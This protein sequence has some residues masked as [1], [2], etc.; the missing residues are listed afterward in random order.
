MAI[1]EIEM[2]SFRNH[3]RT[4]IEFGKGLNVIWG[5]NGSGKTGVLEAIHSLSFGKSFRTNR[6]K[7]LLKAE[8]D[9]LKIRGL[10]VKN[11]DKDVITLHQNK[12]GERRFHINKSPITGL[13]E[14]MG[15]NLVVVLSPEEQGVTKGPPANRRQFFDKIFSVISKEYIETLVQYHRI[16]K[17]RNAALI[18]ARDNKAS[19]EEIDIWDEPIGREAL[20]L[21][22][23]RDALLA[24]YTKELTSVTKNFS[25]EETVRIEYSTPALNNENMKE[26]LRKNKKR[27]IV[28][29]VTNFGPHRD[30]IKVLWKEKDVKKYGSQGEHKLS[31]V[32]MKLAELFYIS[33]RTQQTP[34]LLLD[35]LFAKLDSGRSRKIVSLI[36]SFEKKAG[37]E[38]QTIITTTDLI[39]LEKSGIKIENTETPTF[40]LKRICNA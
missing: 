34:T 2:V 16:L 17:Q 37:H 29:G 36:K 31:L 13:K 7:E 14:L 24:E 12:K 32:L 25:T 21:W 4:H 19:A 35:D 5:E 39:N 10:F 8:K 11:G 9:F 20:S 1:M 33:K 15:E 18:K 28:T 40:H 3:S 26:H 38:I 6:H 23:K 27:D 22:R 30:D